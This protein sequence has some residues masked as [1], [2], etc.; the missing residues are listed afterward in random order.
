MKTDY[1]NDSAN[2]LRAKKRV[3]DLKGFY[4]S[5]M[6]YVIV[7][8][9]LIFINYRTSWGFQWFWFPMFGWGIGLL[10]QAFTVYGIGSNWEDRKIKEIM[11]KN[12]QNKY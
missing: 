7:I 12:S 11:E 4:G 8:P 2:Y 6:A 10:I 3:E 9:F 5:M 1:M